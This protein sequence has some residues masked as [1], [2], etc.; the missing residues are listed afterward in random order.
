MNNNYCEPIAE[1][2]VGPWEQYLAKQPKNDN[3]NKPKILLGIDFW[4]KLKFFAYVLFNTMQ[5][6]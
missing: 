3:D 2:T 6:N 4:M 5:G 1:G